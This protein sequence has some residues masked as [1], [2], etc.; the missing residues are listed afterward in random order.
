MSGFS[1]IIVSL[2]LPLLVLFSNPV[3]AN[4]VEDE[5]S[6]VFMSFY[7]QLFLE[8]MALYSKEI[9]REENPDTTNIVY[10]DTRKNTADLLSGIFFPLTKALGS[11]E[12]TKELAEH[13]N[14]YNAV[15]DY[16][17]TGE[18]DSQS[19]VTH[20]SVTFLKALYILN[21]II[22]AIAVIVIAFVV[23]LAVFTSSTSGAF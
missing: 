1:K 6:D 5:T 3:L 14:I 9:A 4:T 18:H 10:S 11:N 22:F 2:L 19:F 23:G 7:N 13:L 8:P 20:I 21:Q 16:N 12:H 17:N 15:Q